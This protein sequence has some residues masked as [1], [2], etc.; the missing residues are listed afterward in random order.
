MKIFII[1]LILNLAILFIK[2]PTNEPR[3]FKLKN[4]NN[5]SVKIAM[6]GEI[7]KSGSPEVETKAN[8]S[9]EK[10][11]EI[12]ENKKEEKL[13]EVKEEEKIVKNGQKKVVEKKEIK[14]IVRKKSV[15]K[16]QEKSEE[17]SASKS[18]ELA[19]NIFQNSDGGFTAS[20]SDG[21]EFNIVKSLDPE[22]PILAE[23]IRYSKDVIVKTKFL[24]NYQGEVEEIIILDGMEKF[25]FNKAV[26][27]ALKKW[28]FDPIIYNRKPLKVYFTKEFKFTKK[29]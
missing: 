5:I 14:K 8:D 25:G 18:N 28:K 2:I 15:A 7:K 4:S 26:E 1:A 6:G 23:R 13:P 10:V 12:V 21:I 27:E 22:Y 9:N 3:N 20:S 19:D 17:Q 29:F 24:V 16:K 11:E